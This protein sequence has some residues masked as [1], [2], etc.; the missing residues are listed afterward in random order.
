MQISLILL[1]PLEQDT[2]VD[3]DVHEQEVVFSAAPYLVKFKFNQTL[4][5]GG[6]EFK[7][8]HQGDEYVLNIGK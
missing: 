2:E 4:V 7:L 5:N 1:K 8:N 3:V 6:P